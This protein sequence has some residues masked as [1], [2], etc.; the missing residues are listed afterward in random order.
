MAYGSVVGEV[1]RLVA[2]RLPAPVGTGAG[3]SVTAGSALPRRE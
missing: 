1:E 3:E 2:H